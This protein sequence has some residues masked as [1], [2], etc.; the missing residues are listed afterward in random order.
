MDMVFLRFGFILMLKL[1][2]V[3]YYM[4]LYDRYDC[5]P[6]NYNIIVNI[7]ALALLYVQ[8][9]HSVESDDVD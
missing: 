2:N 4:R 7:Q 9:H 3:Y 1:L 6:L 5:Q 8:Q